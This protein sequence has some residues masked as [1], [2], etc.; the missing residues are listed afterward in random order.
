MVGTV[1]ECDGFEG[2]RGEG[3]KLFL[4]LFGKA[5]T[6]PDRVRELVRAAAQPRRG[7]GQVWAGC[8]LRVSGCPLP[9]SHAAGRLH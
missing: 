9:R 4:R 7:A 3:G 1:G 6:C 8:V 2:G 5:G